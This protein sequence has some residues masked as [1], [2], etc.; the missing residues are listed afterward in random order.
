MILVATKRF[1]AFVT[2]I[3]LI[4]S[5]SN[6]CAQES[7]SLRGR[8][9]E[10]VNGD[11]VPN[12]NILVKETQHG[13]FSDGE[14]QFVID[15]AS[16]EY[17]L[18]ISALGFV[19]KEV[20]I[21]IP[22]VDRDKLVVSLIPE[23]MEIEG[24]DVYGTM[25]V[26]DRDMSNTR[27]PLSM[28]PSITRINAIDIERQGAVTITDAMKY[29]PGGWIETRGR[30]TKQFFSVRG[31]RYP[32]PDYSIN[33]I[34]QKDFEESVY[35]MSALDIESIEI[36]RS[37]SA[38]VKGLSGLTGVIDVK[39]RTPERETISAIAKYGELNNFVT[40]FQ[41][42]NKV[43][44][45]SFSTS[46]ALFGT[47]G[48]AGRNGKERIANFSGN[49]LWQVNNRVQLHGVIT[50]IGGMRQLVSIEEPG[51]PNIASRQEKFDPIRTLLSHV[52][53]SYTGDDGSVTEV[54]SNLAY[55][56][57]DYTNYNTVQETTSE[58]AEL[59]YEYGLNILHSRDLSL[60]NT[61]RLGVLYNHWVAPEGKRYYVGR[62]C[63]VHTWSGV[64]ASE[65]RVGRFIF[66][67]GIRLISGYIVEF[68]GFGIEGSAAGFGNVQPIENQYAPF[69]WQSI[70]GASYIISPPASLHYNFSGGTIAP[71]RGSLNE[72]G[73]RPANETRFQH[74]LGFRFRY[75]NHHEISVNLYYNTRR[76]ALELSG[77][78]IVT[79]NDYLMELYE[80]IDKRNYGVELN[81]RIQIPD[82]NSLIVA[83]AIIM[84]SE[85]EGNGDWFNDE[86]MP[87]VILNGGV[88]FDYAGF[89]AN[90]YVHYTGP[91]VNNRFVAASWINQ[92]GDFP[93][94]DFTSIDITAGYTFHT[95]FSTRVFAEARNLLD[96]T[97]LTVAG[98]PDQGRAL[99]M[100]I[101][102]FL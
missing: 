33:G 8:V 51:A 67:G 6:L 48:P 89:D 39:T 87:N 72:Q 65:Q 86:K 77:E 55:R 50:Y 99:S 95:R 94:G 13:A 102:V 17:T 70:L 58:H 98:Y 82:L 101:R 30:K 100:G 10:T 43:N 35:F 11:P 24:V 96:Q 38:L 21:G 68:G 52:K 12:A 45:L 32:Y 49:T 61:L 18:I 56:N 15:L 14:G 22:L 40:N 88:Q 90:V 97:Y 62:A 42:G 44:D 5:L 23:Q 1:Y 28:L 59:D 63:N 3:V 92:Y 2:T 36:V 69:E 75:G 41:Y 74:D 81:T 16:G 54:Q 71:R 73:L 91:Y 37:S 19:T 57:H 64:V 29:V 26:R 60:S 76:D 78:T 25:G 83:N 93:L 20:T 9:Y 85:N 84:N 7:F 53:L 4:G 34:W 80:N 66:D 27:E 46:A 47:D 79:E 31:Q